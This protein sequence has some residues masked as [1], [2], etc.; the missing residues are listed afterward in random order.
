MKIPDLET[1]SMHVASIA[2]GDMTIGWAR[3]RRSPVSGR[4]PAGSRDLIF[5]ILLLAH[6][7]A[8]LQEP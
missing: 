4:G 6:A 7:L 2:H 1:L 5:S 3:N 8:R